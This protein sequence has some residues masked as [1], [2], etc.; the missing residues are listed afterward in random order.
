[1]VILEIEKGLK[2]HQPNSPGTLFMLRKHNNVLLRALLK[3][4]KPK[5]CGQMEMLQVD[6][7]RCRALK[8]AT[9]G[10]TSNPTKSFIG[11]CCAACS[12]CPFCS[13]A[14]APHSRRTLIHMWGEETA[15]TEESSPA[16]LYS[17]H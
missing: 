3:E 17:I 14:S 1:M 7:A 13:F 16:D 12:L 2:L 8:A 15:Q 11:G 9:G 5:L 6:T 4:R 10:F